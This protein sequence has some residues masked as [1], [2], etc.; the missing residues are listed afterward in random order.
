MNDPGTF[1]SLI[2]ELTSLRAAVLREE[3]ALEHRLRTACEE[4]RES[5][6]NF[7]HRAPQA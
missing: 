3:V 7:A 4:H 6:R 2:D 5:A 1:S